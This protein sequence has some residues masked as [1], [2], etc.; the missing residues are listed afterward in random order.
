MPRPAD[1]S[2]E[3][4]S[5]GTV[6]G[7]QLA[8]WFRQG[9]PGRGVVVI[10]HG[11]HTHRGSSLARAR[12]FAEA[13]LSSVLF[14]HRCHG[15]SSGGQVGLG[16]TERH[17]VEAAIALARERCPGEP[18]AVVGYSLGGAA[19]ALA[20]LRGV[21]AVVLEAVFPTIEA[22]VGNR[23]RE[24]LGWFGPLA[25][26]ALLVQL[27]P[28]T[29][30]RCEDLRPVDAVAHLT[31]PVM[32]VGGAT[33]AQTTPEDTRRLFAA[34]NEPK[35]LVWFEGLG[36]QNY[37]KWAPERYRQTVVRFVAEHLR[38]VDLWPP[39]ADDTANP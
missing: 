28:R 12:L 3:E 17:D 27:E 31:C 37:A 8:G 1:F 10:A 11:I 13:G 34:A 18:L 35:E 25:S 30:I 19:A 22:A 20:D 21:D 14:D 15:E 36:H 32:I 5:F 26:W 33:D 23:T 29:G 9:D 38:T 16:H 24:R 6:A 2:V 4:V 39:A 7:D